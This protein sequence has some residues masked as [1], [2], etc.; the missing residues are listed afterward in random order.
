M[1]RPNESTRSFVWHIHNFNPGAN[2]NEAAYVHYKL[3]EFEES[4]FVMI[5]IR[6]ERYSGCCGS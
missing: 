1:S 5:Q 4:D 3:R 2:Y 6:S